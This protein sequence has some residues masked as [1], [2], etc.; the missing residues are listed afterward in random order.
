MSKAKRPALGKGLS[1]LMGM[2]SP[3]ANAAEHSPEKG[4]VTE[5]PLNDI[6]VNPFQ[7]RVD[8]NDE[9]IAELAQSIREQGLMQ[10]IVVRHSGK[11]YQ[12]ISGERRFR[13]IGSLKWAKVPV[14]IRE[15]VNDTKMLEL[16][17]VEN[18]QREDLNEIEKAHSYERLIDDCGLSHEELSQKV[19]KSRSAITNCLRLL[20]LPSDIQQMLRE[21][22]ITMGHA[23]ALLSCDDAKK[24]LL[25]ADK[26]CREGLTVRAVEV[27]AKEPSS[28]P[29]K[30]EKTPAPAPQYPDFQKR[31]QGFAGSTVAIKA[32]ANGSGKIEIAFKSEEELQRLTA[33]LN[34][35]A[36]A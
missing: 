22:Q 32:K 24:Q 4:G 34:D 3:Q 27:L 8:F 18:I 2:D 21:R 1:S 16:A 7:P 5:L 35:G 33:L 29:E 31:W 23:R 10:P 11:A 20:K 30:T 25:L 26:V 9:T 6:V 15:D 36:G 13:A 14:I 19:A 28:Q 12:I 17:L